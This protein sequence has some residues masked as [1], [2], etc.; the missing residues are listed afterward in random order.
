MMTG[1]RH[2]IPSPPL[3]G[4][5]STSVHEVRT[6]LRTFVDKQ[7]SRATV[8]SYRPSDLKN[9]LEMYY[10][11]EPKQL[12]QRLPPRTDEQIQRWIA[13]LTHDGENFVAL[14]GRHV[15]GHT[16]LCDLLD[17]RAELAIFVHQDFRNRGIGTQLLELARRAALAEGYRQIW[18]SVESSNLQAIRVF[19]KTGFQFTGT[20]D[21]ESEMIL[22]L[23]HST[24]QINK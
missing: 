24:G 22:D 15:V 7:G 9:V 12:A 21:A 23:N 8:R 1:A 16:V 20:F 17:G 13:C 10:Q 5:S 2:L 18:I 11:F 3:T 19:L 6:W 4:H 14:V